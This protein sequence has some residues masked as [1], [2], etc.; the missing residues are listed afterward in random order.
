M[1]HEIPVNPQITLSEGQ[2]YTGVRE[3]TLDW[4]DS[5]DEFLRVVC[6]SHWPGKPDC[7][8][9]H[10]SCGAY[11]DKVVI[12][13]RKDSL[14]RDHV[15]ETMG[16]LPQYSKL[17]VT[18]QYALLRINNCW[19]TTIPK[20]KHPA[21]TTMHLSAR[22]SS[23]FLSVSPATV[24]APSPLMV[25]E[26]QDLP[27][28]AIVQNAFGTRL[29]IALAEYR[30]TCGRMTR[31]QAGG[32][33][34]GFI[35]MNGF[36]WD[37]YQGC[38][39]SRALTQD[40]F[41]GAEDET[42]LFDGYEIAETAIAHPT[43]TLRYNLTAVLKKRTILNEDGSQALDAAGDA[44]G[45]NHDFIA[46]GS[47]KEWDWRRIKIAAME[48]GNVLRCRNRYP[49]SDFSFLFIDN[50]TYEEPAACDT[51]LNDDITSMPS[52]HVRRLSD[53]TPCP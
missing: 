24:R 49:L 19:P 38:V 7:L 33:Y 48:G 44:V 53:G 42:L 46:K 5:V 1:I 10:V 18:A 30:V 14:H 15:V 52:D 31:D 16:L 3:W 20:P 28:G 41:L 51:V 45:W 21:G 26:C 39:N 27:S 47:Y 37:A 35:A 17:R 8:P 11:D 6:E 50:E 36:A 12:Q 23:Q 22:G 9:V 2:G 25:G 40:K 4:D 13:Q 32:V 29:I 43:D 34:K